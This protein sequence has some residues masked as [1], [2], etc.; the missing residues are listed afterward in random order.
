MKQKEIRNKEHNQ[1]L[2]EEEFENIL[3]EK[4]AKLSVNKKNDI[5]LSLY[6]FTKLIVES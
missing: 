5:A 6:Q 1:I 2:T 3:G 4:Y